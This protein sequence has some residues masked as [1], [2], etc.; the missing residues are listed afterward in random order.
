MDLLVQ[1]L[2]KKAI[3]MSG[4]SKNELERTCWMVVH[5]YKH[6]A[7]PTEYDIREIDEALYLKVLKTA[8]GMV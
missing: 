5:E 2:S 8:K 7:M 3:D 4:E 1:K 6:G